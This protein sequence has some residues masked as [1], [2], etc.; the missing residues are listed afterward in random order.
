MSDVTV[1][2]GLGNIGCFYGGAVATLLSALALIVFSTF[3]DLGKEECI[4]VNK[5]K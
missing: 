2:Q 1:K 4:E 5:A 3:S